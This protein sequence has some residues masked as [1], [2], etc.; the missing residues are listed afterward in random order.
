M[1][2]S[3][4]FLPHTSAIRFEKFHIFW[5]ALNWRARQDSNLLPF[6][7]P[8]PTSAWQCFGTIRMLSPCT[9]F[10]TFG[11][12]LINSSPC[13]HAARLAIYQFIIQGRRFRRVPEQLAG[14]RAPVGLGVTRLFLK[15]R[16]F[17][18]K[19]SA[20]N[21]RIN[22]FGCVIETFLV[23]VKV[24]CIRRLPEWLEKVHGKNSIRANGFSLS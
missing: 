22:V 4:E 9:V 12:A 19:C 11:H 2:G 23:A 3:R 10:R 5:F 18:Q 7:H 16:D 8:V 13:F 24:R 6:G 15:S 20:R 21:Y 1:I 17:P 14:F